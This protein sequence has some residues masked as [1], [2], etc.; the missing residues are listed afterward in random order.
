[1]LRK[2]IGYGL[3]A[4][5]LALLCSC[6]QGGSRYGK[7]EPLDGLYVE[8][9]S[10]NCLPLEPCGVSRNGENLTIRYEFTA[11][12]CLCTALPRLVCS[13][14]E[15]WEITVNGHKAMPVKGLHLMGGQEGCYELAG[16]VREG[17]N[18]IC[19]TGNGTDASLSVRGDFDGDPS[20]SGGW[21]LSAA[22]VP[23]PGPLASQGLP[24]YT[25]QMA[26]RRS[27]ELPSRVG[28]R[29]LSV[30]GWEGSACEVWINYDKVAD[31]DTKDFRMNVGR[32]LDPGQN[33]IQI[34]VSGWLL[35]DFT[36]E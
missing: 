20:D 7:A 25:G 12:D 32:Y 4:V 31:I 17:L 33:D 5:L 10:D 35:N 13:D 28:R 26:Y 34:R 24:F 1:M 21:V 8:R 3:T 19:L 29:I 30:P 18:V 36:L 14:P 23:G 27:Y 6:S 9:L 11:G 22:G 16:L 2:A 15:L